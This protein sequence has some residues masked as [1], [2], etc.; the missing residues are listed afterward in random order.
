MVGPRWHLVFDAP[1]NIVEMFL[2][3]FGGYGIME[4]PMP[5]TMPMCLG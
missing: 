2:S 4:M 1:A 3:F 5:V